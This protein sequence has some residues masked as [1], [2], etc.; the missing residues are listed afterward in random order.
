MI[1]RSGPYGHKFFGELLAYMYLQMF[2]Q[3]LEEL[4]EAL[5]ADSESE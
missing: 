4:S 1:V 3:V 5:P 2:E